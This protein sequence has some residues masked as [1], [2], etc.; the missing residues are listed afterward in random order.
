MFEAFRARA[1]KVECF[2]PQVLEDGFDVSDRGSARAAPQLLG[3]RDPRAL[4]GGAPVR[5]RGASHLLTARAQVLQPAAAAKLADGTH[6]AREF[7]CICSPEIRHF[8]LMP[9]NS[10]FSLSLK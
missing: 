7:T 1:Y 10:S 2:S 6:G 4:R 9:T 3:A 8:T 5:A